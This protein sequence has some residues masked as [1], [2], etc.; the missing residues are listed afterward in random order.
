MIAIVSKFII[1]AILGYLIGAIPFGMIITKLTGG[2]DIT[3]SGSGKTGATNVL[4]TAGKKSAGL[5]LVLDIAKGAGA[6]IL[7]R[8]I[9]GVSIVPVNWQTLPSCGYVASSVLFS[10]G[11]FNWTIYGV[12]AVVAMAAVI[13][14]NWSP[15]IKFHGGRGVAAF[16]GG[17]IPMCWILSII[18]GVGILMG[19][20]AITR[21]MSLGSILSVTISGLAMLVFFITGN[22]PLESLVYTL[23]GMTLILIQHRDNIDRL[24]SGTERKI[25]AKAEQK[26]NG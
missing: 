3:Q 22:Q 8:W 5:V 19:T 15:Y 24:R 11:K 7:A 20:A 12:Q 17:M 16:F 21:Y 14:H 18:C 9:M 23:A 10:I 2:V 26:Q 1:A 25:G 6:V 4:R 13:G